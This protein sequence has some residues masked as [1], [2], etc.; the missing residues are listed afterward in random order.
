MVR[1]TRFPWDPRDG[2]G[3]SLR[4]SRR[5]IMPGAPKALTHVGMMQLDCLDRPM[6]CEEVETATRKKYRGAHLGPCPWRH[7]TNLLKHKLVTPTGRRVGSSAGG[8]QRQIEITSHGQK[9][10]V[11]WRRMFRT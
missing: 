3:C 10:L 6:C 1:Q 11:T 2:E 4:R 5:P 7:V 9:W 8:Q